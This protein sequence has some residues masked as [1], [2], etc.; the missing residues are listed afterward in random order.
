MTTYKAAAKSIVKEAIKSA[1]YIDEKAREP[2]ERE[3]KALEGKLSENLYN[4]FKKQ[5]ITLSF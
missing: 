1:I 3:N 5:N 4:V 2:F